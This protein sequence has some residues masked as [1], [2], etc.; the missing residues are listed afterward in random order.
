MIYV[1]CD[2]VTREAT[3]ADDEEIADVAW[4][5]NNQ[6]SGYLPHPL[7]A[8]SRTTSTCSSPRTTNMP[9]T[10]SNSKRLIIYSSRS[11]VGHP[12]RS[13]IIAGLTDRI[14]TPQ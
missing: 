11:G 7:H 14:M 5:D 12:R 10:R 4:S 1:A 8:P 9:C 2:V 6:L 13:P 3:V